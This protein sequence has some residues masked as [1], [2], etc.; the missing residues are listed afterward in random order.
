MSPENPSCECRR[1]VVNCNFAINFKLVWEIRTSSVLHIYTTRIQQ[2]HTVDK[3]SI[4]SVPMKDFA[5]RLRETRVAAGLTQE[6]LAFALDVT[7][8]SVSAWENRREAPSFRL[9]PALANTLHTSLDT[10]VCNSHPRGEKSK[11]DTSTRSLLPGTVAERALLMR[12][13]DLSRKQ[14]R[15]LL[16]LLEP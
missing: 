9:L 1:S 14:Q 4:W 12:Y 11:D 2:R 13:R 7:K 3:V 5:D 15:A 6:Q 8:S 10:L 16:D